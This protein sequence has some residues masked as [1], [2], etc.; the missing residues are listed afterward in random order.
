MTKTQLRRKW[1]DA[2]SYQV[3]PPSFEEWLEDYELSQALA[4]DYNLEPVIGD[5]ND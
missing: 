3:N 4:N 2:C 5:D 1:R